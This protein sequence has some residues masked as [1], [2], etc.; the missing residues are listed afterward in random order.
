M[1]VGLAVLTLVVVVL[2]AGGA[3]VCVWEFLERRLS[4]RKKRMITEE[5]YAFRAALQMPTWAYLVWCGL[6]I[7]LAALL[8]WKEAR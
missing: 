4:E 8:A 7:G 6:L 1:I 2:L 5:I 3:G